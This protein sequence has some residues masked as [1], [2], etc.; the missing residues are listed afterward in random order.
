MRKKMTNKIDK[1]EKVDE[2][3]TV[4]RYDNGFMVDF[5]GRDFSGDYKRQKLICSTEKELF[6]TIKQ[7]FQMELDN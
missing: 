2:S 6:D 3:F 5:S 7:S 1:L 4:Y